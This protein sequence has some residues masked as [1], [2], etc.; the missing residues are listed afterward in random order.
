MSDKYHSSLEICKRHAERLTWA[1][2]ELKNHFPFTP[3]SL[4]KFSNTEQAIVDQFSTRFAKLQDAMGVN[5]F[6]AVLEL[7]KEPPHLT[8]FLDRLYQLEKI[9]AIASAE[10]W[11]LLREMRNQFAHDYPEDP[12]LQ[13]SLLNKAYGLAKDLMVVL[14]QVEDFVSSRSISS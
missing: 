5:L 4:E 3:E 13:S 2:T 12:Q 8:A 9:G 11:L 10:H 7:M 1:M 6:P 14:Q